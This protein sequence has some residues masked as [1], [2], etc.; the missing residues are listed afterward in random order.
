MILKQIIRY[1]NAPA[2]EATWVE[3]VEVP[4]EQDPTYDVYLLPTQ[5]EIVVKCQAYSNGQMDMLRADLGADAAAH[6]PLIAEIEATYVEPE[7]PTA[8]EVAATLIAAVTTA[9]QKR[10]DDFARTRNYDTILS[11]ATYATSTVP[12]F[13][14]EGQ[15]AV[16]SRDASWAACYEIMGDV[17]QGLRAMPTVEQVLSELPA[18]EWPASAS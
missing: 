13:A 2:L 16:E 6:E 17:Q 7:P 3:I 4:Q 9:V 8:E 14:A 5:Q 15:Y 1:T 12:T 11:A 10:L 18:L